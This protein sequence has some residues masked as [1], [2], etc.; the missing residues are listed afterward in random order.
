M[1]SHFC[2]LKGI[3]QWSQ[4]M[5]YFMV[6]VNFRFR[7]GLPYLFACLIAPFELQQ[8]PANRMSYIYLKLAFRSIN[9]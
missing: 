3:L 1:L 6:H 5:R 4:H 7:L 8:F 2:L 9:V